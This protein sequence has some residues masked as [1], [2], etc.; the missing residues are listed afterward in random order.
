MALTTGV[1]PPRDEGLMPVISILG[2]L[3]VAFGMIAL[4]NGW[5]SEGIAA[6][7]IGIITVILAGGGKA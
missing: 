5:L 2:V 6:V 3:S 7:T 4:D 1:V